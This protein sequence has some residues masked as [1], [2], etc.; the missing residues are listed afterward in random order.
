VAAELEFAN[1]LSLRDGVIVRSELS[2]DRE[3]TLQA[4]GL[5]E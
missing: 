2:L 3:K 4:A 5:R 1:I